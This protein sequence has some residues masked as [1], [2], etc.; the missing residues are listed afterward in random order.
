MDFIGPDYQILGLYGS[1]GVGKDFV[2]QQIK[3]F[4]ESKE[5]NHGMGICLALADPIKDFASNALGIDR[6]LLYGTDDDKNTLTDYDW[7]KMPFPHNK[8]G[9]MSIRHIIQIVGTE[10]GR[11]VWDD[12][13]WINAMRRR[14]QRTY[15][16]ICCGPRGYGWYEK[17]G[18]IYFVITDVRFDNEVDAVRE[19]GGVVWSVKGPQRINKKGD[20]H[21]SEQQD[22]RDLDG[23]I[24]NGLDTTEEDLRSQIRE[25]FKRWR[26]TTSTAP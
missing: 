13:L 7:E 25:N 8:T 24:F 9:K 12:R 6:K 10:L 2:G 20:R 5:G 18:N 15:E 16:D 1:K 11:D 22:D 26:S 19:W 4:V 21:L 23:V 14:I 3:A 17:K